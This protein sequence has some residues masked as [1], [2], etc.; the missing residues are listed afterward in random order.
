MTVEQEPL[1]GAA[2]TVSAIESWCRHAAGPVVV[3]I[4]G[5]GASGKTTC[6]GLLAG[7]LGATVV[8]TDD[9]FQQPCATSRDPKSQGVELSSYYDWQRV[10]DEALE[11]LRDGRSATYRSYDW[12]RRGLSEDRRE[13]SP[14]RVVLLE[15][16]LS[17]AP[18]L[19]DLVDR[20][21]FISTPESERMR[22]LRARVAPEDW[23]EEWL[24]AER[25]YFELVRP[26][27]SFDLVLS[28]TGPSGDPATR[29]AKR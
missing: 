2:A 16:V 19:A 10:R 7:L 6:A 27:S 1:A 20:A 28:G 29:L 18:Q 15:G 17:A 5:Y 21:V 23:D 9:F 13:L 8:H 22:R 12:E 3:A 14:S 24:R 11:P 26:P 4:D 25:T